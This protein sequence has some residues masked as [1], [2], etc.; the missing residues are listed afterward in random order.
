MVGGRFDACICSMSDTGTP[1]AV[2]FN[3]PYYSA[4]SKRFGVTGDTT[5][6]AA[7]G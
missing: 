5:M 3:D 7:L 2:T 6:L 1:K 4:R